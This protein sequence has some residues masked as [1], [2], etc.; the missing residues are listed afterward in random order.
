LET[1]L[2]GGLKKSPIQQKLA[3][4]I[5][6]TTEIESYHEHSRQNNDIDGGQGTTV[7]YVKNQGL[8]AQTFD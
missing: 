1:P 5:E 6:A 7:V 3:D 4:L 2:S 8:D